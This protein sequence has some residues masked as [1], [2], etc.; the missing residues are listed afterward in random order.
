MPPERILIID[1]E[2]D[3]RLIAEISLRLT[4][5]W[6]VVT[7]ESATAG[8]TIAREWIPDAILLDVMMPDMNGPTAVEQLQTDPSTARIPV[9]LLTAKVQPADRQ[10]YLQI[11]V[12]GVIAKPFDPLTLGA[13]MRELLGWG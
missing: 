9:V 5:A 12:R 2:E 4:E 6:E 13:S 11:G 10:R 7:A 3:I 8:L 1:D